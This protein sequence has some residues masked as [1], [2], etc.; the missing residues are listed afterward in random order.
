MVK[1]PLQQRALHT[2]AV[3][4]TEAWNALLGVKPKANIFRV[5]G[6][7]WRLGHDGADSKETDSEMHFLRTERLAR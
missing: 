2:A 7:D 3:A 1:R 4:A 5:A 6:L